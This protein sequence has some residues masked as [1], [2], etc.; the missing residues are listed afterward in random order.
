[1]L[2]CWRALR[3]DW[4]V[5]LH[6][7]LWLAALRPSTNAT[8]ALSTLY[9]ELSPSVPITSGTITLD[10]LYGYSRV[11]DLAAGSVPI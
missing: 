2:G 4:R 7:G 9:F 6:E 8:N 1:M 10:G 11:A 3:D 5:F